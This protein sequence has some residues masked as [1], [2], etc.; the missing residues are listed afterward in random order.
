M[1]LVNGMPEAEPRK[2]FPAQIT[3]PEVIHAEANAISKL[4]RSIESG[5]DSDIYITHAPCM[6]CSKLIY[7]SGIKNVYYREVYNK[8]DGIEFLNS[9]N[10]GVKQL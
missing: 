8:T 1:Y 10:I 3:K 6:S 4:A 9:C 7:G 2:R 5:L